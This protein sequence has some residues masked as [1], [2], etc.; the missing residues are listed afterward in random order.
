MNNFDEK[1]EYSSLYENVQRLSEEE[2]KDIISKKYPNEEVFSNLSE[3]EKMVFTDHLLYQ[4]QSKKV[5]GNHSD[6]NLRQMEGN[7]TRTFRYDYSNKLNIS[8]FDVKKILIKTKMRVDVAEHKIKTG[9]E[10][11]EPKILKPESSSNLKDKEEVKD[12]MEGLEKDI[13]ELQRSGRTEIGSKPSEVEYSLEEKVSDKLKLALKNHSE[14]DYQELLEIEHKIDTDKYEILFRG[15]KNRVEGSIKEKGT[16][17]TVYLMENKDGLIE[18]ER[19]GFADNNKMT[20]E[21]LLNDI[22]NSLN[23]LPKLKESYENYVKEGNLK[24]K[25]SLDGMKRMYDEKRE[26]ILV[27]ARSMKYDQEEKITEN[28]EQEKTRKMN[29][30]LDKILRKEIDI[31]KLDK[32]KNNAKGKSL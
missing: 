10:K 21:E 27:N 18:V 15:D 9:V 28:K 24:E 31:P 23:E 16:Y 22:E 30:K 19:F 4:E 2:K 11:I 8:Y 17:N 5:E 7:V 26:Q 3:T 12:F 32:A 13:A 29:E 6:L 14:A 1:Y 25:T 20:D